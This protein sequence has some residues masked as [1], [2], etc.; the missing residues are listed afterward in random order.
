VVAARVFLILFELRGA[1]DLSK[2]IVAAVVLPPPRGRSRV[3]GRGSRAL[4]P[5]LIQTV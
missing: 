3:A 2:H 5:E 4:V 1:G